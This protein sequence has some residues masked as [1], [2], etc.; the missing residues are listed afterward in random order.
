MRTARER[1]WDGQ[2][3]REHAQRFGVPAFERRLR[4]EV[5]AVLGGEAATA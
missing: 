3:M 4:A 1:A 2:A 5:A